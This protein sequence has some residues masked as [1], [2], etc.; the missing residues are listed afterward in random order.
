M[1]KTNPCSSA[2]NSACILVCPSASPKRSPGLWISSRSVGARFIRRVRDDCAARGVRRPAAPLAIIPPGVTALPPGRYWC[3]D[4]NSTGPNNRINKG[5]ALAPTA[6]LPGQFLFESIRCAPSRYH[7]FPR[8]IQQLNRHD[9]AREPDF[10]RLRVDQ[11]VQHPSEVV[12]ENCAADLQPANGGP[13]GAGQNFPDPH[14]QRP[15]SV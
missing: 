6:V 13:E 4:P 8:C 2:F 15:S 5:A 1:D 10:I 7:W 11:F 9:L 14:P 3:T 12:A